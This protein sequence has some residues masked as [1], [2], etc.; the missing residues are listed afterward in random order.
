MIWDVLPTTVGVET[1][2][3]GWRGNGYTGS[4][5]FPT[6]VFRLSAGTHTLIIR[7]RRS[8][9]RAQRNHDLSGFDANAGCAGRAAK[10]ARSVDP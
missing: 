9:D 1:R 10:F 3:V 4:P 8:R 5:Q 6:K 7:G 2:T